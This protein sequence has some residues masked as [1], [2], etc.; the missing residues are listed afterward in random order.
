MYRWVLMH[1]HSVTPYDTPQLPAVAGV[2][3]P[4][5]FPVNDWYG[6]LWKAGMLLDF[7]LVEM[8]L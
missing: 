6:F 4:G 2:S 5:G 8:F 7:I 1:L 3:L